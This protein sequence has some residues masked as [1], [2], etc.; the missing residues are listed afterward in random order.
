MDLEQREGRVHRYKGHAVR[1]NLAADH[2]AAALATSTN[3]PWAMMFERARPEDPGP[4][5]D[6]IPYWIYPGGAKIQ[7]EVPAV[8]MSRDLERLDSLRR[9]MAVYRMVFGQPRQDDLLEYILECA[10]PEHLRALIADLTIDLTPP[11]R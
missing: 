11:V 8:P 1:K 10:D 4:L 5:P 9:A 7:R 2:G 3:D 6:L